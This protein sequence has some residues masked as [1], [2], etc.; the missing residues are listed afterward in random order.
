MVTTLIAPPIASELHK[1]RVTDHFD[2]IDSAGIDRIK[3]LI[4]SEAI[5]QVVPTD[6]VDQQQHLLPGQASHEEADWL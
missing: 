2:V 5:G 4:R 1:S 3:I 6:A